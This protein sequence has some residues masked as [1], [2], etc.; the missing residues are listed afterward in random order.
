MVCR[1]H[2][3]TSVPYRTSSSGRVGRRRTCQPTRRC[4]DGNAFDGCQDD[5]V[6]I[7]VTPLAENREKTFARANENVVVDTTT[8]DGNV[9]IAAP[10]P[11]AGSG[12][13]ATDES[14][15]TMATTNNKSKSLV[16]DTPA[17][18]RNLNGWHYVLLHVTHSRRSCTK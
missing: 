15:T 18:V 8:K 5:V 16:T 13:S 4:D 7:T 2:W 9:F 17:T 1:R 10:A 14:R 12:S 11:A 6:S 3:S